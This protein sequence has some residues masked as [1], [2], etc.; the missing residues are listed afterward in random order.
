[1]SGQILTK[2]GVWSRFERIPIWVYFI[3]AVIFM[4]WPLLRPV[5][6]QV[7]VDPETLKYFDQLKQLKSGDNVLFSLDYEVG[8]VSILEPGVV[9]TWKY[10]A[11][12]DVRLVVTTFSYQAPPL[13][14]RAIKIIRPESFGWK[15]GENWVFMGYI[16]GL[17]TGIAAFAK[18]IRSVVSVDYY[19]TP[20]ETIPIMKG[21]NGAGDFKLVASFLSLIHI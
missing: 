20:I 11:T 5:G 19:G 13:Y 18:N 4:S 17:E 9:A 15:Y 6:L 1:M 3:V 2:K 10:L 14:V 8:S 12:K 7:K 16:P 21:I